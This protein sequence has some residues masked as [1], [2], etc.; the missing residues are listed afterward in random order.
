MQGRWCYLYRVIDS[1]GAT[2]DFL[3]SAFRDAVAAKQLF[4]NALSDLSHPQP[5]VINTALLHEG[6]SAGGAVWPA[7]FVSAG[8]TL[9]G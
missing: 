9:Q 3:L 1:S 5:R 8:A 6:P 4:C 2:I 7:L